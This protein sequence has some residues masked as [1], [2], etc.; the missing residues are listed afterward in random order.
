M[1]A[2][3]LGVSTC[4]D[5]TRQENTCQKVARKPYKTIDTSSVQVREGWCGRSVWASAP[6]WIQPGTRPK[7]DRSAEGWGHP[8]CVHQQRADRCWFY[9][10]GRLDVLRLLVHLDFLLANLSSK[11]FAFSM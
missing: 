10:P 3:C 11:D 9:N 7:R 4:L 6:V 5:T 2:F 1:R 8:W